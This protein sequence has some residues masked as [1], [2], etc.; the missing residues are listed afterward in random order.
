MAEAFRAKGWEVRTQIG[1]SGFRVDLGVVHPDRAGSYL[2]GI[3]CD[4]A[5]YHS[6][7]TVRDRDKVRQV[8]LEGLG[9]VPTGFETRKLSQ[10]GATRTQAASR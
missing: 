1:V 10:K 2:S 8:V 9:W 6:P 5:R 3:E 7:A 4:G